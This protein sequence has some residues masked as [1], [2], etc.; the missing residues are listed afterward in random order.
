MYIL[1][2]SCYSYEISLVYCFCADDNH[3]GVA[4]FVY[5]ETLYK[6][7]LVMNSFLGKHDF[8]I[9]L[10]CVVWEYVGC[11][12]KPLESKYK[13]RRSNEYLRNQCGSQLSGFSAMFMC[14]LLCSL[15][16]Q[17]KGKAIQVLNFYAIIFDTISC[18]F[19]HAPMHMVSNTIPLLILCNSIVKFTAAAACNNSTERF[20]Q[21]C[22]AAMTRDNLDDLTSHCNL[23]GGHLIWFDTVQEFFALTNRL[24]NYDLDDFNGYLFTGAHRDFYF[25]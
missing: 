7:W 17:H 19:V 3:T 15:A 13:T 8:V 10:W 6:S 14:L 11:K 23:W 12:F 1:I 2:K 18:F 5:P 24:S 21:Y 16:T 25:V 22:S 9:R 20:N 4:L